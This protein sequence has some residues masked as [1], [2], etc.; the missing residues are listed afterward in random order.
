M[1]NE[2]ATACMCFSNYEGENC[3]IASQSVKTAQ[4]IS[5]ATIAIAISS[6]LIFYLLIIASDIFDYMVRDRSKRKAPRKMAKQ[7]IS[8]SIVDNKKSVA[9]RRQ[10]VAI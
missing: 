3:E 9:Q 6:I 7:L 10:F 1:M 2:T 5:S 4:Q 8:C